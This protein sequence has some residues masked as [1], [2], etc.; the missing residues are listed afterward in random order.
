MLITP[1]HNF[2]C[3]GREKYKNRNCSRKEKKE[4]KQRENQKIKSE[5]KRRKN[6]GRETPGKK[7]RDTSKY[8]HISIDTN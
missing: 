2:L 5:R 8:L 3:L 1:T 4:E 6:R 7:L